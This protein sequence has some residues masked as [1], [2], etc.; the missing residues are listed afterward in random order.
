MRAGAHSSA[1]LLHLSRPLPRLLQG[2]SVT[3]V[4]MQ[5]L[6]QQVTVPFE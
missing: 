6:Q 4:F 2:S 3:A 1:S 5:R